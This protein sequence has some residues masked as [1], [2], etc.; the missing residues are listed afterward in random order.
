MAI[1]EQLQSDLDLAQAQRRRAEASHEQREAD[2]PPGFTPTIY[3]P[4]PFDATEETGRQVAEPVN[5]TVAGIL[6]LPVHLLNAAVSGVASADDWLVTQRGG[7]PNPAQP[8]QLTAPFTE[9]GRRMGA[10]A[11]PE[12]QRHGLVP[13]ISAFVGTG[14]L[15]MGGIIAR[16]LSSLANPMISPVPTVLENMGRIAATNP[17]KATAFDVAANVSAASGG[18]IARNFT[19]DPT[20]IA[21]SQLGA[22]FIPT[23]L[24]LVPG[25]CR[26][27]HN[28]GKGD[29]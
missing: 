27:V 3:K 9:A 10:I 19:E 11:P 12:E 13:E 8:P 4:F 7:T 21:L 25:L 5:R 6:D 2:G 1:S 17:A 22:A 20:I 29:R 24:A 14:L 16:G 18:E 15:G 28:G 26:K 23:G